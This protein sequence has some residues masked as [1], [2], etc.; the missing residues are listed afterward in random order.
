MKDFWFTSAVNPL[1][2]RRSLVMLKG[3]RVPLPAGLCFEP[4]MRGSN[5]RDLLDQLVK[6]GM[7]HLVVP[8][9]GPHEDTCLFARRH[10]GWDVKSGDSAV[11][12]PP[13]FAE[14][15]AAALPALP[16]LP[17]PK[18][19][20]KK[21]QNEVLYDLEHRDEG[22]FTRLKFLLD[23]A[24]GAGVMLGFTLFSAWPGSTGLPLSRGAN[25][26][27]I[28]LDD[29]L[30]PP[31]KADAAELLS[32][33]EAVMRPTV[34]WIAAEVRGR[35]AVWVQIFRGL[36]DDPGGDDANAMHALLGLEQNLSKRLLTAFVK[37][38]EDAARA[39][40][41]PWVVLSANLPSQWASEFNHIAPFDVKRELLPEKNQ[42]GRVRGSASLLPESAHAKSDALAP[43]RPAL[44]AFALSDR[45]TFGKSYGWFTHD[46]LWRTAFNGAWPIVPGGFEGRQN[47]RWF[48][49]SR[50]SEFFK[51]WAGHG[52][53]RPC[54]EILRPMPKGLKVPPAAGTDGGGRYMVFFQEMPKDGVEL[55][56][57]PG[58]YRYYWLDP[59]IGRLQDMGEGLVGGDRCRV[60]EYDTDLSQL[61]ILEQ[62][63]LPDPM[64]VW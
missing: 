27:G 42:N 23:A 55:A 64:S 4:M 9:N 26:Q 56:T 7:R 48:Y 57:P 32:K 24:E 11:A 52:Y 47:R 51:Q 10:P 43:R 8:L 25:V 53:I 49:S 19:K 45:D 41:G 37:P 18:K 14:S 33:L 60:P 17:A 62:E 13:V 29:A 34:D 50:M 16:A 30:N 59:I 46:L 15:D 61:L 5:Q 20:K 63:E 2:A 35:A 58:N 36:P 31:P 12:L 38:G 28:S 21:K 3:H 40:K 44:L 1:A 22:A 6:T 54:P 39:K